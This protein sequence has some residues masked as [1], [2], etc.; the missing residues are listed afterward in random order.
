MTDEELVQAVQL[1]LRRSQ[2]VRVEGGPIFP[3]E[4]GARA[5]RMTTED[6]LQLAAKQLPES[7]PVGTYAR[8]E[9]FRARAI[10]LITRKN[11]V[12]VM[13]DRAVELGRP[14]SEIDQ[15]SRTLEPL[16]NDVEA[17]H[18]EA[19]RMD[20]D[21]QKTVFNDDGSIAFDASKR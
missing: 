15:L 8:G 5:D 2:R 13:R 11:R 6:L 16:E 18:R 14:Q 20:R 17:I 21:M 19:R 4:L 12:L 9:V 7:H 10:P 1:A 3:E